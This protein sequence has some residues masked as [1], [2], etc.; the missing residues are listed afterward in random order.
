MRQEL[1]QDLQLFDDD[2]SGLM[3]YESSRRSQGLIPR[4]E[5]TTDQVTDRLGACGGLDDDLSQV[6]VQEFMI[7]LEA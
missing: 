2:D 1:V 4:V 7:F 5:V 6:S 3:S